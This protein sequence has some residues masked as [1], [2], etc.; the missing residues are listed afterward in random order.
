MHLL[1]TLNDQI[2][3]RFV[4][5]IWWVS[6]ISLHYLFSTKSNHHLNFAAHPTRTTTAWSYQRTHSRRWLSSISSKMGLPAEHSRNLVASPSPHSRQ[7]PHV[8]NSSN[9]SRVNTVSWNSN[10]SHSKFTCPR[11]QRG[12]RQRRSHL[13]PPQHRYEAMP[14]FKTWSAAA[15]GI[16]Y[17]TAICS[18]GDLSHMQIFLNRCPIY[19][20]FFTYKKV[21]ICPIINMSYTPQIES[22]VYVFPKQNL[23]YFKH[24]PIS[25]TIF[26]LLM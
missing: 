26:M 10:S 3:F 6:P 9:T 8:S 7:R 19:S 21:D 23:P 24:Y 11:G 2:F 12:A 16:A 25:N 4:P 20:L 1:F 15:L 14:S 17:R 13:P 5:E 22:R 18:R